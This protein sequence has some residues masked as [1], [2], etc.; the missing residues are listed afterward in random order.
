MAR[1][2]EKPTAIIIGSGFGGL[3]AAIEMGRAG[4]DYT[5]IEKGSDVGGVWRE[6]SYPGA[7]CDIPSPL[8]SFSFDPNPEWPR[9]FSMQPDILSYLQNIATEYGVRDRTRFDTA[10]TSA[11][12]DDATGRWRVHTDRG[13]DIEADVLVP[14]VG[15]L[16]RPAMPRI[17]GLDSFEGAAF[18]SAQWDHQHDLTGQRVAVI[19]TGASAV[20]FVPRIQPT[21][22]ELTLFQRS[23]PFVLPK[24]DRT[25]TRAH[26]AAFRRLPWTQQIGRGTFWGAGEAMTLG[27]TT[28]PWIGRLMK[29][30]ALTH[31]KVVVRDKALRRKLTPDYPVGCKR[32]LFSSNYLPSLTKPNVDV[33]TDDVVEITPRG[34]RTAAGREY[35]VD[36]IIYGTGFTATEFLAPMKIVG[37]DGHELG[38]SWKDGARAYLGMTVP[39][40][41]NMFLMYG[42]NT[43]LGAGSI[44]FMHECQARYL[45][46]A[47]QRLD[48]SQAQFIDVDCSVEQRFDTEIQGRVQGGVWTKCNNWYRNVSGRVSANW[49]GTMAEYRDRTE[50]FE[51]SEY[52][53]SSAPTSRVPVDTIAPLQG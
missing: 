29:R 33:V 5:V 13:D 40:F 12:F 28:V 17:P 4:Y 16:S 32:I 34:V 15:Q 49:P 11:E 48:A 10:V 39:G 45:S 2:K 21:V 30:I 26:H 9:R 38:E 44:V 1:T 18:H 22:S 27:F 3:A 6:N 52:V 46:Q 43:N 53:F 8:Y 35:P 37:L 50:H 36:T 47:M 42:P 23:A 24:P 14:A 25:Y 7:G 20:Q 41:P 19:G 51:A 31:L